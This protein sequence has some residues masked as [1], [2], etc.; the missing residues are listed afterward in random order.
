M[1]LIAHQTSGN[2]D[3][4]VLL[5][6]GLMTM[7]MWEPIAVALQRDYQV[8]RCDFR[9][10]LLSPGVGPDTISGHADD[11]IAVLDALGVARAHV[12]GTSF[13]GFIG[14]T[15]AATRHSRVRS[16][17]AGTTTAYIGDEE[18]RAARPLVD[19]CRASMAGR[20][21]PGRILDLVS[22]VTYSPRFLAANAALL[23]ER[24][25]L[26][27]M[28]P[29]AYFEGAASIVALLEHLDLRPLLARIDCPT[30]VLAARN[31]RTF[32]PAHAQALA[33]GIRGARLEILDDASHG[34]FIEEAGRV[35]PLLASFLASAGAPVDAGRDT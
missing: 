19:A 24:R 11:V 32:P 31:D 34:V 27:S 20:G 23:D 28:M 25:L 13:G 12:V 4:V 33:A 35:A 8:I 18:W 21:D 15:L 9:G 1:A 5:N 7:A 2:G 6:G 17:V 10:Q 30:L 14:I 3:A 29:Q 22:P 16:L 26:L